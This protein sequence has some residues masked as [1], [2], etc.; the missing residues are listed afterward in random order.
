[1]MYYLGQSDHL[2]S[3]AHLYTQTLTLPG[4]VNVNGVNVTHVF[5]LSVVQFL[6]V[7]LT[8]FMFTFFF[9]TAVKKK[10]IYIFLIWNVRF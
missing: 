7:D 2:T 9:G 1:M 10:Y 8:C 5:E 4:I 3:T 6:Y